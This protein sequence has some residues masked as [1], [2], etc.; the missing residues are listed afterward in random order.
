MSPQTLAETLFSLGVI[1]VLCPRGCSFPS[2]RARRTPSLL[3]ETRRL[4]LLETCA[5]GDVF[6]LLCVIL[7]VANAFIYRAAC[8]PRCPRCPSAHL[9]ALPSRR[10]GRLGAVAGPPWWTRPEGSGPSAGDLRQCDPNG[11]PSEKESIPSCSHTRTKLFA[12][13]IMYLKFM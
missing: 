8:P 7:P 1:F 6:F 3:P 4:L 2:R 12:L 5:L 11:K 9:P 10:Y 13:I